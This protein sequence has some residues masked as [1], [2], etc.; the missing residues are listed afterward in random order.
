M[1]PVD[2]VNAHDSKCAVASDAPAV[3]LGHPS[4]TQ[5][6]NSVSAALDNVVNVVLNAN[7]TSL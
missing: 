1:L 6:T 4:I 7:T 3:G 5:L 2:A